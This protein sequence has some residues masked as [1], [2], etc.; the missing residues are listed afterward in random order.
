MFYEGKED[1]G[2]TP[3]LDSLSKRRKL[4]NEQPT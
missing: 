3:L 1:M 4:I 2:L